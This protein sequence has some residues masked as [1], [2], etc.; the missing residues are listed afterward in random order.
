MTTFPLRS[1]TGPSNG[2][3]RHRLALGRQQ[4][5]LKPAPISLLRDC[6]PEGPA[7]QSYALQRANQPLSHTTLS[8]KAVSALCPGGVWG[9][10]FKRLPQLPLPGGLL[11][12]KALLVSKTNC[13]GGSSVRYWS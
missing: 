5:S 2:I 12:V 1:G 11:E 7:S 13:S 8:Q 3:K 9:K 4:E 10:P 6:I